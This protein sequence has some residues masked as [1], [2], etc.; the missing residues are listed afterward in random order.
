M[1]KIIKSLQITVG[2]EINKKILLNFSHDR[3]LLVGP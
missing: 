3:L 1:T 2:Y